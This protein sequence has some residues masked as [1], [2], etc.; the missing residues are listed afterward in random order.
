MSY[1]SV[2]SFYFCAAAI[3]LRFRKIFLDGVVF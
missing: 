1:D 2:I 3:S